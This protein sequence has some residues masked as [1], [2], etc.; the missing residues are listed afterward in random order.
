MGGIGNIPS[1]WQNSDPLSSLQD[2]NGLS[3]IDE[4]RD[5][6]VMVAVPRCHNV[7][8]ASDE[9][10]VRKSV[11]VEV[12]VLHRVE[13]WDMKPQTVHTQGIQEIEKGT[14]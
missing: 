5:P 3:S 14:Q 1:A 4:P 12:Q 2:M 13:R 10:L 6:F 9:V 7:F 8:P 11:S